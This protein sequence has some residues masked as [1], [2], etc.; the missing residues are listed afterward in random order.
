MKIPPFVRGAGFAVVL[1]CSSLLAQIETVSILP[2][3]VRS[4]PPAFG[5]GEV[6]R[7][8]AFD[9]D[10]DLVQDFAV[11]WS[12]GQ[13][14][15]TYA[16]ENIGAMWPCQVDQ[17][18]DV[19]R[20]A[21]PFAPP[22]AT[23]G[24]GLLVADA[25]GLGFLYFGPGPAGTYNTML[26]TSL[27]VP[28]LSWHASTK[29]ESYVLGDNQACY[30]AALDP[31]SHTIR[32][33]DIGGGSIH[34]LTEVTAN[35]TVQQML[36][37]DFLQNGVL[38][39]VA[40]TNAGLQVWDLA[41]NLVVTAPATT[42]HWNGAICTVRNG[43]ETEVAW[44]AVTSSNW[45]LR[46]V[47]QSASGIAAT[48][49]S[50]IAVLPG[51]PLRFR[52][53]GLSALPVASSTQDGLLLEQNTFAASLRLVRDD[54]GSVDAADDVFVTQAEVPTPAFTPNTDNCASVV[55]DTNRDGAAEIATVRSQ[56][57]TFTIAAA[58]STQPYPS[59]NLIGSESRIVRTSGSV[60]LSLGIT[61]PSTY[62]THTNLPTTPNMAVQVTAWPQKIGAPHDGSKLN[63]PAFL[64]SQCG[65]AT[66]NAYY[67]WPLGSTAR[68]FTVNL[69]LDPADWQ[70]GKAQ[71]YLS[72]RLV[73][74]TSAPQG[75]VP[76]P[77]AWASETQMIGLSAQGSEPFM[78]AVCADP[79]WETMT[80]P[81]GD[82]PGGPPGS[83]EPRDVG[84]GVIRGRPKPPPEVQPVP[85]PSSPIV[86]PQ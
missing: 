83:G 71:A 30:L 79:V 63:I 47:Y 31:N 34:G 48:A 41:G 51:Q 4:I 18:R 28:S 72:V 24:D 15:L 17:A 70:A 7:I 81:H 21:A 42:P 60:H 75:T 19:T 50:P 26:R 27:G 11:L 66:N 65:T 55:V 67:L 22:Q 13:V 80:V 1:S 9:C 10:A 16:I 82:P 84:T 53:V 69:G 76:K 37:V 85:P 35:A 61:M 3:I 62:G 74:F 5:T 52:V 77:I 45:N 39:L 14:I 40:R 73:Q 46:R 20:I 58:T 57:L 33:G 43:T 36:F 32:I 68:N 12:G 59:F 25:A 54:M 86:V 8:V 56:P 44:A 64:P 23:G 2:D 29:L 6:K 38:H 49:G 78:I